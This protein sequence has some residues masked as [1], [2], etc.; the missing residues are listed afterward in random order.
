MVERGDCWPAADVVL[1]TENTLMAL[2][3]SLII[4]F[5]EGIDLLPLDGFD[6]LH[7]FGQQGEG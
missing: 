2:A 6:Q 1:V 7:P 4:L 3:S 5:E